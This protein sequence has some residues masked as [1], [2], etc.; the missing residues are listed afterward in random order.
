MVADWTNPDP[1][2]AA[3][4]KKHGRNGIPLYLMYAADASQAP[5]VLPQ[6]LTKE[7]VLEALKSVSVKNSEVAAVL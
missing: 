7:I 1:T 3:L 4:L 2:I 6:L 5:L